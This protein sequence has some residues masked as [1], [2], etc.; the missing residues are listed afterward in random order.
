MCNLYSI[1]TDQAAIIALL[2]VVNCY[3]GN[4]PPML[5]VEN[6]DFRFTEPV[7]AIVANDIGH[8][9]VCLL[10]GFDNAPTI[11]SAFKIGAP[12]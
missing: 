11:P 5:V 8:S 10:D 9:L 7:C 2:R 3:V 1:T 4:L 6:F 12:E